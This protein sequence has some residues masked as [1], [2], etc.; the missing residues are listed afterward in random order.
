MRSK[1]FWKAKGTKH[2]STYLFHH[3]SSSEA[4]N[5]HSSTKATFF[6]NFTI[7]SQ[8]TFSL[9]LET[10]GYELNNSQQSRTQDS[11]LGNM[12]KKK[13][14][15]IGFQEIRKENTLLLGVIFTS[16]KDAQTIHF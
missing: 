2:C 13:R 1:V 8:G 4:P 15:N 10:Q 7:K 9:Q 16:I 3:L 6:T 14:E 12:M 5:V 11:K